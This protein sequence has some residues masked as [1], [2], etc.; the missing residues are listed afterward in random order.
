M[1]WDEVFRKRK[2]FGDAVSYQLYVGLPKSVRFLPKQ[3]QIV[4][5]GNSVLFK[6]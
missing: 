4:S 1:Q 3:N 6:W 2:A 5:V